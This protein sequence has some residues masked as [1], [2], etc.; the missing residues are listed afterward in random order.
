MQYTTNYPRHNPSTYEVV[1]H[2][3]I[4]APLELLIMFKEWF[5]QTT[6]TRLYSTAIRFYRGVK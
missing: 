1:E 3:P 2:T 4:N 6:N 5:F